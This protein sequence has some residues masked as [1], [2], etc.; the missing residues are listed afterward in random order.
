MKK[1]LILVCIIALGMQPV[2]AQKRGQ[3]RIDSLL[4]L[5][6]IAKVDSQQAKVLIDLSFTYNSID[7]DKGISYGQQ[8]LAMAERLGWKSGVSDAYRAIGVNHAFGKSEY[9]EAMAAF[10][11]SLVI[12]E[13]T[14]D[15]VDAAKLLNN[16]GVVYWYLSDFP[17]A[18]EYYFK[19]LQIHESLGKK[20][21]MANSLSNIGLV[22]NSQGDFPKALEYLIKG[23][24]IDVE[25]GNKP[26]IAS[27]LGNIGQIYAQMDNF[28]KA[29]E[30]DSSALSLYS[31]L[32]DKNGIARNL[33]NIGGIYAVMGMYQKA[34][35]YYA[36]ALTISRELGLQI[37]IASN[38][39]AI[40]ST[41]LR[42]TKD[43][44]A[45][46]TL[47]AGNRDAALHQAQAYL[48]SSIVISKEIG[49]ISSLITLYERLSEIQA[50]AGNYP[51]ALESYKL[52]T[53]S[54]DSVFNME[55]DKKLTEAAMQ[56]A[57]DKKVAQAKA[58]QEQKDIRQR[59]IRNTIIAGLLVSLIF[60]GIV[61]RQRIRIGKEKK[62]SDAEKRRSDE[63]LLNILPGE[64]ADELK[65]TG[66]AKAKAF[67]MVT[68]MLTDFKDFTT[69]SEKISA[70]LLVAEIHFCFSAFDHIIQK[71]K[72]EKIKTIGDAY[73]CASGLPVSN[74][75]HATEILN[76]A[77]EIRDFMQRRK[78]EKEALGE[79]PFEIRIGV[80][81]GPVVAGIVGVKK[82]AYDIWGDT[83]NLAARMEQ[84]SEAGKINISQNT[85][86]LVKDRFDCTYRGKIEAKHK[87]M[88]SMYFAEPVPTS[89][90]L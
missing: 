26:G 76:A 84:N 3:A 6:Q 36:K 23:N 62:I 81:T 9:A 70:E 74:Y 32:G 83:V 34:L 86:D 31:E 72:I 12:A 47:F 35:D 8:A 64:V 54:K 52:Y 65:S 67:T 46:R 60:S 1:L 39:G 40:G 43:P 77:V 49:D 18:I 45:L 50:L 22:Y 10:S 87:G 57:F 90:V 51:G 33:G 17:N 2:L 55:K 4:Q 73:L 79:I 25:L 56:Y 37:G 71:Y 61:I 24:E 5:V 85:Y 89:E 38:L 42:V 68:V 28:P 13:E 53:M 75:S 88:V 11:K 16:M 19:A 78:L 82:Y 63:L 14:G 29:L 44:V 7:P 21:E 80:H 27:N 66:T 20:D 30:Y 58:E 48:D 69:I 41:Y 59:A 15:R